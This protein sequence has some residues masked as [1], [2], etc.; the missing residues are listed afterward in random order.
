MRHI[1]S[2]FLQ[3]GALAAMSLLP[4]QVTAGSPNLSTPP[5]ERIKSDYELQEKNLREA[6]KQK[7]QTL[8]SEFLAE[9]KKLLAEKTRAGNVAGMAAAREAM[10]LFEQCKEQVE[11]T[12]DFALPEKV[13]RELHEIF[14]RCGEKKRAI[15]AEYADEVEKLKAKS[16]EQLS[17][18]LTEQGFTGMSDEELAKLL[19]QLLQEKPASVPAGGTDSGTQ[20]AEAGP[21]ATNDTRKLETETRIIS[22]S[23]SQ[24]VDWVPIARWYAAVSAIE[25]IRIPVMGR[26]EREHRRQE[27]ETFGQPFETIYEPIRVLAPGPGYSFRVKSLVGREAAEVLE[28]PTPKNGWTLVVRARP[29]GEV[30]S[31]HGLEIEVGFPGAK[32]LAPLQ[33]DK[34][35]EEEPEITDK[36]PRVKITIRTDPEGAYVYIDGR[37]YRDGAAFLQTPCTVPLST[38][39][40]NIRL[41]KFGYKDAAVDGF[42]PQEGRVVSLKL[43][44][45]SRYVNTTIKVSAKRPWQTS[46][47][48]VDKGDRILIRATGKWCCGSGG[49]WVDAEGYPNDKQ[50]FRYY[51][52]P[53]MSPRQK[54]GANYGA[55]LMRIGPDGPV[56]AVGTKFSTTAPVD[57]ELFFDINEVTD[58]GTRRDNDGVLTVEI[59][60]APGGAD[61][62]GYLLEK[63]SRVLQSS[64]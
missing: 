6:K 41:R 30:P 56:F 59:K 3:A 53:K 24:E 50:F 58:T 16:R 9:A 55:L 23:S 44:P 32:D 11:K 64:P 4:S 46:R 2:C 37:P 39:P 60:K 34:D 14:T 43:D 5:F 10:T 47:I 19:A 61:A 12:G 18:R 40:H 49:E 54:A 29:S 51:L 15:D 36:L 22:T 62:D 38:K 26:F 63:E 8:V 33:G 25:V 20:P 17:A 21:T 42:V 35:N 27:S 45:D 28:W 1:L 52:N 7:F 48:K 13:R 31:R 57:G